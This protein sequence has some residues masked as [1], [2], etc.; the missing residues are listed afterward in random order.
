MKPIGTPAYLTLFN[1]EK[2]GKIACDPGTGTTSDKRGK[3][4]GQELVPLS[5]NYFGVCRADFP[6]GHIGVL[7][8]AGPWIGTK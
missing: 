7:C 6:N 1:G 8:K 4:I 3:S 5:R 2:S